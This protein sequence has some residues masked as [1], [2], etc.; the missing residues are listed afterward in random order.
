MLC[1]MK[2]KADII[3]TI[4]LS[5]MC[6]LAKIVNCGLK[7]AIIATDIDLVKLRMNHGRDA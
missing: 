4:D 3:Q 1:C 7:F 5:A 2:V 6:V